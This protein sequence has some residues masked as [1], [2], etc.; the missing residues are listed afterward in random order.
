MGAFDAPT[1]T[2]LEKHIF[3]ADKGDYYDIAAA[4]RRR[5]GGDGACRRSLAPVAAL[6]AS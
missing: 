3:S 4:C 6:R 2:Q 1:G 5:K